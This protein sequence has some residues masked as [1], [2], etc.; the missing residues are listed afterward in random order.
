LTTALNAAVDY[1]A[2]GKELYESWSDAQEHG[3]SLAITTVA[4]LDKALK[5]QSEAKQL[6]ILRLQI[7]MRVIGLGWNQF[8]TKWSAKSDPTIGTVAHLKG[9]LLEI[10]AHEIA[11]RRLKRLPTE[12]APPQ[13]TAKDVGQLGTANADA[14]AVKSKSIFSAEELA[15]KTEE[16][17]VRREA[18]GIADRVERLQGPVPAFNQQ[19]VGKRLEVLWKYLLPDGSS[20]LIWATGRVARVADGLTDKRSQRAKNLLPGGAVLWAWDADPE[21]GEVA[22]EKWL[23]LL[24]NKWNPPKAIVYGWRYD[25]RELSPTAA[26]PER[27]ERLRGATR[28]CDE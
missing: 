18:S 17:M 26:A 23:V 1:Y 8:R 20:Q 10:I 9:L 6:E 19:L 4:A 3:K 28:M 16:A 7:D 14:L 24:P 22:G 15:R 21:F 11:E 27:D 13:F 2:Y 12:A 25:P 5:D